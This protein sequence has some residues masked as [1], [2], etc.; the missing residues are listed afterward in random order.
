MKLYK[1]L[2][3]KDTRVVNKKGQPLIL[4]R[5]QEFLTSAERNRKIR[6]YT[7]DWQKDFDENLFVGAEEIPEV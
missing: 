1:S 6:V 3:I 7:L 2:L 5:G 4:K